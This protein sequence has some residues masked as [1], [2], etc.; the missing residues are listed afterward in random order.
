[1]F[2]LLNVLNLIPE[3]RRP[4]IQRLSENTEPGNLTEEISPSEISFLKRFTAFDTRRNVYINI[5]P[6]LL[7]VYV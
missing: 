2:A 3:E 5:S 6:A 4:F 1:M 7:K